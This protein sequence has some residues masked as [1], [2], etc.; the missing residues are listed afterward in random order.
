MLEKK[1]RWKEV[2][3]GP[4]ADHSSQIEKDIKVSEYGV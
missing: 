3:K 4:K 1:S 2:E